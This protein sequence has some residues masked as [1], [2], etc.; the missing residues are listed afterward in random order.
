MINILWGL[1]GCTIIILVAYLLSE[2]KKAINIWTVSMGFIAQV[3][4]GFF[5]LK[6]DVRNEHY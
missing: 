2:N 6:W 5:V 1:M 4:L 3:V